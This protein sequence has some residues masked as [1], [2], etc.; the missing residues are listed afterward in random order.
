[1]DDFQ[2]YQGTSS[3]FPKVSKLMEQMFQLMTATQCSKVDKRRIYSY[4]VDLA[5]VTSDLL[6]SEFIFEIAHIIAPSAIV[7]PNLAQSMQKHT[8]LSK[9]QHVQAA[10]NAVLHFFLP[11][12]L[13]KFAKL[14]DIYLEKRQIRRICFHTK[15]EFELLQ[16]KSFKLD[17]TLTYSLICACLFLHQVLLE[18]FDEFKAVMFRE[19]QLK[20]L[21]YDAARAPAHVTFWWPAFSFQERVIFQARYV[22]DGEDEE[23]YEEQLEKQALGLIEDNDQEI[24]QQNQPMNQ[25]RTQTL[26]PEF[27]P[28]KTTRQSLNPQSLNPQPNIQNQSDLRQ[29]NLRNNQ[30]SNQNQNYT[31][32]TLYTQSFVQ[33]PGFKSELNSFIQKSREVVLTETSNLKER[34]KLIEEKQEHQNQNQIALNLN[35]KQMQKEMEKLFQV[36]KEINKT[37]VALSCR[38]K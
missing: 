20:E 34:I 1:M 8:Y 2:Q 18:S 38:G 33:G 30:T 5:A 19:F 9:E 21:V 7:S 29:T 37:V 6:N 3:H 16:Y 36:V 35:V 12:S 15:I 28:V 22:E 23:F 17:L 25:T 24:Q 27:V 13:Q 31:M 26:N 32:P 11:G 14:L 10:V 4:L